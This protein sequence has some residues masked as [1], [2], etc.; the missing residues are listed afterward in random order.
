MFYTISVPPYKIQEH[1]T[2]YGE[3]DGKKYEMLQIGQE[4]YIIDAK[5]DNSDTILQSSDRFAY[6]LQIGNFCSLATNIYFLIGR[7]KNVHKVTTATAKF[8]TGVDTINPGSHHEKG[9]VLIG[10]DVWVGANVGIMSGV[11]IHDGAVIAANSH[12]VRDVPAYAIVGGNPAKV[13]GYRF[14]EETRKKL[15]QI[16]WWYWP[17]EKLMQN[18]HYFNDDIDAFCQKFY[19]EATLEADLETLHVKTSDEADIYLMLCDLDTTHP[20]TGYVIEEFIEQFAG[21][22]TKTLLIN[23]LRKN[24]STALLEKVVEDLRKENIKCRIE[25]SECTMEEIADIL[26]KVS[27]VI[28]NRA[29]ETIQL[30]SYADAYGNGCDYISGVDIPIFL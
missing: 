4:S 21:D 16:Q 26:P 5:I 2:Y 14:E 7:N 30:I 17:M 13:I 1:F 3:I 6:N 8:L 29:R 23:V 18:A 19:E 9:D 15:K 12:V 28:T 11:I 27:H 24:E 20:V 10:N 22:G 25:L